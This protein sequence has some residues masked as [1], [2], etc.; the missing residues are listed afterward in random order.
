MAGIALLVWAIRATTAETFASIPA[1]LVLLL[2]GAAIAAGRF[3]IAMG[4]R[5]V[6]IALDSIAIVLAVLLLPVHLAVLVVFVTT[7]VAMWNQPRLPGA[8]GMFWRV[9]TPLAAT[10]GVGVAGWV[11]DQLVHG[12]MP[13]PVLLVPAFFVALSLEMFVDACVVIDLEADT[14]GSWRHVVDAWVSP[15]A[16]V[17]LPTVAAAVLTPYVR[18]DAMFA[19]LLPVLIVGMYG[20][21]WIANSQQLERRRSE[22][23]RDTFSRYVPDGV[24]DENLETMQQVELG[25]EQHEITVLFCDIR[26]FTS[27]SEDKG[28]TEVI[29]ELNVLLTEL[30]ASVME[31][32]GTLDKFTGDGLM[33]FWGAPL[34]FVDH[35]DRACRAA[36]DMLERLERVNELRAADGELPFAVGVGVHSG[37]AVVGNVG[38]ER[39]LDY[40][41]IGDT[42]NTTARLEAATKEIGAVLVVSRSTVDLLSE[43]LRARALLV[44]DITMKGKARPVE[45]WALQPRRPEL[46]GLDD[47]FAA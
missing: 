8:R 40:T 30:S 28:A 9:Y 41:A 23:L 19:L 36:L 43:G 16:N 11:A 34:P 3:P 12:A 13:G 24:V 2:T 32:G 38:H 42:V 7:N 21:L 26:G 5:Q 27:W 29:T 18:D 14:P 33:A 22:R 31:T 47:S 6:F 17:F 1:A 35:A 15:I 44:G 37:P 4:V 10:V 46:D 39:R 25:G 20:A 45:A